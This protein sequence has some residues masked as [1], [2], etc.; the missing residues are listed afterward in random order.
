MI[1]FWCL[2]I[3]REYVTVSKFKGS[4]RYHVNLE[5][6]TTQNGQLAADCRM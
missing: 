2:D 3:I 1:Q 6:V 5:G 4:G